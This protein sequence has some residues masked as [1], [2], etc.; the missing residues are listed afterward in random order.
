MAQ[1]PFLIQLLMATF[2]GEQVWKTSLNPEISNT[3]TKPENLKR[4]WK[5]LEAFQNILPNLG[6]LA[7]PKGVPIVEPGRLSPKTRLPNQ[8]LVEKGRTPSKRPKGGF[9]E[10]R[11]EE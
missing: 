2:R 1:N 11:A 4:P 5:G 7:L 8:G 6:V 10:Q 3:L 9:G